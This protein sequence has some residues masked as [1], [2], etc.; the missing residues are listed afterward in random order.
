[1]AAILAACAVLI[2]ADTGCGTKA[3]DD[4]FQPGTGTGGKGGASG[5]A[6]AGAS[7]GAAGKDGGASGTSGGPAVAC[8]KDDDCAAFAATPFCN[9]ASSTCVACVL[10]DAARQCKTGDTCC[11]G[12]CVKIDSDPKNCGGC[13]TACDLANANPAC[14]AGKCAVAN[15]LTDYQ[16]CD[17][18]PSNG[19]ETKG[20]SGACQCEPGKTQPCYFGPAGTQGK[21]ECKGGTQTCSASAF[22]GLCDGEVLPQKEVCGNGKDE[23]CNGKVDDS[24]DADGDGYAR[25]AGDCC[26]E[27]GATCG[28]PKLVN[29]GAVE[30]P[31]DQVD[32]DCDG[33]V[34]EDPVV[35]CG[36]GP[37]FQGT[38]ALDLLNAMEI[39]Q[40]S[41]N[42]S[43]GYVGA[44]S[45]SRA[46]GSGATTNEQ[47]AVLADFGNA[48][49]APKKFKTMAA[50]SSGR[51]RDAS[52]PSP[53]DSLSFNHY[54]DAAPAD[55]LL[56][57]LGQL[58]KTSPN[59]PNGNGVNDGVMLRVQLKVPT[60]AN[61]F[62]FQFR[63]FSQEY[64]T[65]TCTS[66]ND[67]FIAMLDT[68]WQPGPG[69]T[70]I[71]KD[72]NICFDQNGG[73]IS[74]NTKSFFTT[75]CQPKSGYTCPDGNAA[76]AGTGYDDEG[77]ATA[78]LKT[79]AP[80]VP[81]ETITLRF[82]IWDT[83]DQA[84]DSLVLM[85]NFQWSATPSSGPITE[86]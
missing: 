52:D 63:F 84:W 42:G 33:Q 29:P 41:K 26:D 6:G 62:S 73:Y 70:P 40:E 85:D 51:A 74:V 61:S 78:W 2:G 28:T 76:L 25:C 82:A 27:A 19:C 80:V 50:M 38:T 54:T 67:F 49:N 75:C 77:G 30:V 34:D 48:A 14:A 47:V 16:D 39:C 64:W 43:W 57:H 9:P 5:T 10:N 53:T 24:E 59:C 35:V 69:Q 55:F 83:S 21:G 13:G 23:D 18:N 66:F 1:V 58:P 22:W 4:V 36:S 56:P 11:A 45:L 71:P 60:N 31:G 37:K 44:P 32:N 46:S 12:A 17:K 86:K 3:G 81:G 8:A 79:T 15:C 20:A 65:W 7:G 72:K 68:K